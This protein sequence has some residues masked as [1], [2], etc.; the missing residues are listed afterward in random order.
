MKKIFTA[1]III[2]FF[3]NILHAQQPYVVANKISS[4][5]SFFPLEYVRLLESPFKNAMDK[6]E[7]YLLSLK[8]DRFLYRFRLNAGLQPKDSIYGGWETAE[9]SG[10]SLG[11]YLSACSMMYAAS[12]DERFKKITD[13]IVDELALCQDARKTGYVGAIPGEDSLFD[14]IASGD[15]R[16]GADLNG[17][18]VPW[19]TLHKMLAGLVDAYMY[20]GNAKALLIA[21]R[22]AD[23]ASD[24]FKNLTDAQFQT[25]LNC[26]HGGMNEALANIYAFT[27]NKKY[28]DLSYRFDHKKILDTLADGKDE[29]AGKHANTQIPKVIGAAR[30]YELTGDDKEE[31]TADFFWQTVTAHHTYVIGGNSDFEHFTNPDELSDHLST[32][33][34]ET[35]NSYNM[36]KLTRHLF[37][38]NAD[39]K[40]MDYYERTLYNHILAS[41]NPD[42]GMTCYYVPLASGAEKTYAT[43]ETSFW[44]CTGTGME[45]HVKYGESIYAKGDDGSLYINLFI[46][47]TLNWKEKN[48]QLSMQTKFP[49][50]DKIELKI[51]NATT[52]GSFPIHI[53]YPHWA[54]NIKA[55][56]NDKVVAVT[57]DANN[58]FTINGTW[59]TGDVITI[60]MPM[61]IYQE[62]MPDNANRVALLYGPLVLAG[63]LGKE[64]PAENNIPVFVNNSNDVASTVKKDNDLVFKTAVVNNDKTV[65]LIP[66]YAMHDEHYIVYW[67]V[68]TKDAWAAKK[69]EYEAELKR[70]EE[71]EKRTVDVMRIGEMQPERDHNVKGEQT[72]TGEAF[73]RK[74]RDAVNGGWF[75]FTLDTKSNTNLQLICTYWGSDHGS[76]AFDILVDDTKIA[77][78]KLESEKPNEFFDVVYDIPSSLLAGKQSITVKLQAHPASTAGGLFGCSLVKPVQ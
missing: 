32:N 17:V 15:I 67:D 7:A 39:G 24:K 53:R 29:L 21:G 23:W 69:K 59:K 64:K 66:F 1:F 73:A 5:A 12:G 22:F 26:E 49:A 72:N 33:T 74:W 41:I 78:Q 13:Y 14:Q 48:L 68:F 76:R 71:L 42:N 30:Q 38:W 54:T 3:S 36:L 62:A 57:K 45:N 60:I 50:S 75:S 35:C 58:Y 55:I 27:G 11:H 61:H 4:K 56:V 47:S 43:P 20:T 65:S 9:V 19:Y 6:D 31:R 18:W 2:S 25:M 63:E 28:L 52:A 10:H 34:T 46:P 70:Q 44:C 40:Y 51:N 77:T 16:A 37:T 8:P